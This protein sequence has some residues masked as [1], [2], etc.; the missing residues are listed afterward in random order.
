MSKQGNPGANQLAN[1][2][3]GM[4]DMRTDSPL[5]LDFGVIQSDMSLK[6]NTFGVPI[7]YGDYSICRSVT[8]DSG[9]PLTQSYNDGAH[10]HPDAG[11]GGAHTHN[12]RLPEKMYRI[13]PGDRVLVA[14]V[15][16]EAVVVDIVFNS[17]KA[18]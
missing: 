18:W 6:T 3:A 16:E 11:Y 8:Y 1:T 7:P 13:K 5:V 10:G 4:V 15:D 17:K 12:I 14:W 2:L 9:V